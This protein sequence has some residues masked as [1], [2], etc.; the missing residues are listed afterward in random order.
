MKY[1]NLPRSIK[2]NPINILLSSLMPLQKQTSKQADNWTRKHPCY[3]TRKA[4]ARPWCNG[5]LYF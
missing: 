1:I 4:G 2:V 5:R 3:C